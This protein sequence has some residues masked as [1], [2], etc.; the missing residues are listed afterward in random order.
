MHVK[1]QK[2]DQKNTMNKRNKTKR[3]EKQHKTNKNPS[4]FDK[5]FCFCPH[6]KDV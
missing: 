3:Q 5:N 6:S 4:F 1:C 2:F